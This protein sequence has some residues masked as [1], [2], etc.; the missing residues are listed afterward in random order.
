MIEDLPVGR[1][2]HDQPSFEL[3]FAP[4]DELTRAHGGVRG[5]PGAPCPTSR[6]SPRVQ[7]GRAQAAGEP[8]DLHVFPE[9]ALDGRLGVFVAMLT[10][11]S[12]GALTL[13]GLDP[14]AAPRHR[15]RPA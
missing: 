2:L 12:R 1:N 15:P 14:E 13:G 5:R 4:S 6:G 11:R 3:I 9:I 10:P 7:S 8:F